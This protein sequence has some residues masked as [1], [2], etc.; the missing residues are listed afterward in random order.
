MYIV[1]W[2]TEN[3]KG[4]IHNLLRGRKEFSFPSDFSAET[5]RV[6]AKK[7][8]GNLN[9]DDELCHTGVIIFHSYGQN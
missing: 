6:F 4:L 3:R 9:N 8:K 5:D 7:K 1:L 2:E